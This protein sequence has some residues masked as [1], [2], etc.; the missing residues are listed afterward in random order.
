MI[1]CVR[2]SFICWT[3]PV[4]VLRQ[5]DRSLRI[6]G[7]QCGARPPS[8]ADPLEIHVCRSGCGVQFTAL[9]NK[10][11]L[12]QPAV[13]DQ[14]LRTRSGIVLTPRIILGCFISRA[15]FFAHLCLSVARFRTGHS[16]RIVLT[17][18]L[19]YTGNGRRGAARFRGVRCLEDR[20]GFLLKP[21]S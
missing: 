12:S 15:H 3:R 9:A 16:C 5:L 20:R 2:R 17:A 6:V 14:R 19:H 10:N 21:P 7:C 4:L 11:Q 18:S 1:C 8:L 13:L